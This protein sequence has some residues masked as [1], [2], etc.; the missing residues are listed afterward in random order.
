MLTPFFTVEIP[1]LRLIGRTSFPSLSSAST[2]RARQYALLRIADQLSYLFSGPTQTLLE[3]IKTIYN[4]TPGLSPDKIAPTVGQN[5]THLRL[6]C[7]PRCLSQTINLSSSLHAAGKIALPSAVLQ[8]WDLGG[9]RGIRSIWPKYYDDC[10]AVVYVVDA[11]DHERLSEGWEVFG[12]FLF[13]PF[14]SLSPSQLPGLAISQRN[15]GLKST[16]VP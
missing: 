13:H 3:K 16:R 6:L 8:F 5:S 4:D 1:I 10:H 15:R 2:A 9:Q 12:T 14:H 11:V 7:H